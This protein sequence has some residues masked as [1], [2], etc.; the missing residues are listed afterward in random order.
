M[1]YT[2]IL[3]FVNTFGGLLGIPEAMASSITPEN[4]IALTNRRGSWA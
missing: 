2:F 1:T 4:I 3:L